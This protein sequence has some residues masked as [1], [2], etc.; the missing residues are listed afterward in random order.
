LGNSYKF[1]IFEPNLKI[2]IRVNLQISKTLRG[3]FVIDE[4]LGVKLQFF[5]MF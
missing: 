3:K 1:K 5:E 2:E 4:S